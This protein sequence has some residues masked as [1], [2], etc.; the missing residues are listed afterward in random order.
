MRVE[1]MSHRGVIG[2]FGSVL[3]MVV[4]GCGWGWPGCPGGG[5]VGGGPVGGSPVG[6]GPVGMVVISAPSGGCRGLG[7]PA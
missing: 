2:L 3:S 1:M 5:P 4:P 6:G 7:R